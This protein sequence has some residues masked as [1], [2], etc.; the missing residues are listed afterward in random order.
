MI[1]T[2]GTALD[3]T[4]ADLAMESFFPADEMT[5]RALREKANGPR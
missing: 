3:L 5:S 2:L 4:L 1:S